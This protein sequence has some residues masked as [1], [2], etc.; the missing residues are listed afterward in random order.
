MRKTLNR[1]AKQLL[2]RRK[3]LGAAAL[4]L[5]VALIFTLVNSPAIVGASATTRKLPN[6]CVRRDNKC[7]SLTFDAA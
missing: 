6:Y 2:R 7:V 4:V 1:L 3:V 5:T